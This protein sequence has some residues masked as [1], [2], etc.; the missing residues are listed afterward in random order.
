MRDGFS[1]NQ[2]LRHLLNFI[3]SL[4][5]QR[6]GSRICSVYDSS[7][8]LVHSFGGCIRVRFVSWHTIILLRIN[9]LT[10]L[11]VHSVRLDGTIH[12]LSDTFQIIR[13]PSCHSTEEY[14][15][16]GA[17]CQCHANNVHDLFLR[18]QKHFF[19]Q[20]LS[21]A[22][23]TAGSRNDRNLEQRIRV[24]QEPTRNR[25]SGFVVGDYLSFLITHDLVTFKTTNDSVRRFLKIVNGN[26]IRCPPGR[27]NRSL[28][29]QVGN[30]G[31]G[32]AGC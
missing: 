11:R 23:S 21:I 10:N 7:G 24:L 30:I 12:K 32:K 15:L 9:E 6:H 3:L 27:H 26:K 4:S 18:S 13:S 17:S 2:Q 16:G 25:V 20:I 14:I 28:V 31:S 1:F 29:A 8:F 19:R 22:K 5:D